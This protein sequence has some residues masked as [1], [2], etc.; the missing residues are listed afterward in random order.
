MLIAK[1]EGRPHILLTDFGL[2]RRLT[3]NRACRQTMCGT[4]DY[5]APDVILAN[6]DLSEITMQMKKCN[7][8]SEKTLLKIYRKQDGYGYGRAA[9]IWSVGMTAF[10]LLAGKC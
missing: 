6:C 10:V 4:L 3:E 1:K 7:S 5:M 2:A 8:E 9:D